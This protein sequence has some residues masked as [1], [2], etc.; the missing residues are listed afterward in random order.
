MG[1]HSR[2]MVI[3]MNDEYTWLPKLDYVYA[4][5][6]CD[7]KYDPG[8]FRVCPKFHNGDEDF[9][10][11]IPEL[12]ARMKSGT[13]ICEN[14]DLLMNN[15]QARMGLYLDH[16]FLRCRHKNMHVILIVKSIES[17]SPKLQQNVHE[18]E[19]FDHNLSS[20]YFS[21]DIKSM[22]HGSL[23]RVIEIAQ[24]LINGMS[25]YSHIA[26]DMDEVRFQGDFSM[27]QLLHAGGQ[28]IEYGNADKS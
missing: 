28:Q 22:R 25:R 6:F 13:I 20:N 12:V 24:K 14:F 5:R 4:A 9:I 19:F 26:I 16:L 2:V 3:D 1:I 8:K 21:D 27:K 17:I 7:N 15:A 10:R 18:V 11:A 23:H